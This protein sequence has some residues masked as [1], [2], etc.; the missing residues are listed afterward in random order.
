MGAA[1]VVLV[2]L[3]S[4]PARAQTSSYDAM[5]ER[6]MNGDRTV[7]FTAL[8]KAFTET[9][10]YTQAWAN[11]VSMI[12][13]RQLWNQPKIEDALKLA[14][15][16]IAETFVDVNAHMVAFLA[17]QQAGNT[18]RAQFHRFIADGLLNSI[19]SSG[20]G[21]TKATAFVVI[22]TNEEYALLVRAM[23]LRPAGVATGKDG[24]HWYDDFK[25]T[26]STGAEVHYI[27][28]ID[29]LFPGK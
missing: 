10:A 24:D 8:R 3:A 25:A 6:L 23:R 5:V 13:Y 18:E 21:K 29:K 12:R 26:D 4:I 11:A 17:Y 1:V 7:D 14:T 2:F 20:D 28:N 22:A 27:F 15:P 19:R 16:I 9:P